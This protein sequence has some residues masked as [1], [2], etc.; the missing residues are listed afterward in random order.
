MQY[1][2]TNPKAYM[3]CLEN[4]WRKEKLLQVRAMIQANGPELEESI[5][6]KMLAYGKGETQVFGLNA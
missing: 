4:D 5:L 1:E 3:E 6:Y 2:A